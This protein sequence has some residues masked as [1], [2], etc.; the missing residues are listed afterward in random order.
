MTIA[1]HAGK[2]SLSDLGEDH[3][4]VILAYPDR[5]SE[6]ERKSASGLL[7]ESESQR[8]ARYRFE[9]D[10][11]LFRFSHGFLRVTL[12]RYLDAEPRSL[13][14][15]TLPG[16]R[17]E[18]YVS[19]PPPIRFNLSHTKGLVACVVTKRS[20]CGV[21][22]EIMR[23]L[24]DSLLKAVLTKAE[25]SELEALD[26]VRRLDRFYEYWTLKEAYLKGRG[27]GLSIPLQ[28]L[29]F[30]NS[31]SQPRLETAP[32]TDND[33]HAWRFSSLRPTPRHH[34]AAAL[35]VAAG[36]ATFRVIET[37]GLS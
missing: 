24:D 6:G 28:Q 23:R 5:A 26:E 20:A 13:R 29:D 21:D 22:A 25:S 12:S 2:L 34:V 31:D 19:G 33:S 37:C 8:A 14:F 4:D 3:A 27:L 7:D 15:V 32:G 1:A 9:C 35:R 17:P 16:G 36:K 30:S 10:R 18:L 11:E